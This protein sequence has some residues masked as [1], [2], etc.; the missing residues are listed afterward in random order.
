MLQFYIFFVQFAYYSTLSEIYLLDADKFVITEFC[1]LS[2]KS[3]VTVYIETFTTL[4][5]E[6]RI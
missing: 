1:Q 3:N 2:T 6:I 5:I 4:V